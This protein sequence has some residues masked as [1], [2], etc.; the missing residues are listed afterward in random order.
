MILFYQ[1]TTGQFQMTGLF[2]TIWENAATAL[3]TLQYANGKPVPG[4]VNVPGV[5][6]PG[7]NGNY[8]FAV[9]ATISAPAGG[10]YQVV[11]TVTCPDGWKRT[12]TLPAQIV[13]SGQGQE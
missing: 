9:P 3:A 12:W 6:V 5:Y 8:A 2:S 10:G 11:V 1:L 7:S 4:F 13:A